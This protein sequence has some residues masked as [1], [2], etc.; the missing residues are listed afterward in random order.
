MTGWEVIKLEPAQLDRVSPY[1]TEVFSDG[2]SDWATPYVPAENP[3][4]AFKG[5]DSYPEVRVYDSD[6]EWTITDAAG[7]YVLEPSLARAEINSTGRIVYGY[8]LRVP[9]AGEYTIEFYAPNVTI[10][11]TDS[12]EPILD[13]GR[14]VTLTINVVPGGGK[15]GGRPSR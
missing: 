13:Y 9:S 8:N 11:G 12:G 10:E 15:G 4:A 7:N 6:A 14:T 1:G 3:V 5:L 2:S